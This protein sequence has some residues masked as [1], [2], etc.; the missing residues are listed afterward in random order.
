MRYV[1]VTL[2][3]ILEALIDVVGEL[4]PHA[5]AQFPLQLLRDSDLAGEDMSQS[6]YLLLHLRHNFYFLVL[7]PSLFVNPFSWLIRLRLTFASSA[8][9]SAF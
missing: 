5:D 3:D 8:L 7:H 2:L 6:L 4:F 9:H 1:H